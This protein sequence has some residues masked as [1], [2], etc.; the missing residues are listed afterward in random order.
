MEQDKKKVMLIFGGVSSEHEVS[1]TSAAS[2]LSHINTE[3]YDIIKVGI[4]KDGRWMQTEAEPFDIENGSWEE[5][6]SNKDVYLMPGAGFAGLD[7]DIVFPLLHG[8]NGEDGRMQGF[9]AI[10]GIPFVGS[11]S[12]ASAACMDKAVT[13]AVIDQ[14]EACDQAK[15]CVAHRGCDVE[16]AASV[17]DQFF[18]SKYPLFVKPANA[19]SSVGISKV[20]QMEGLPEAL[21][22]AFA[23]DN[24]AVVEEAIVGREIEVA[25]LGNEDP[26]ASCIGEILSANEF[27]DY[28]AKY[29]NIGSVTSIVTDLPDSLQEQIRQT[30][31]SIYEIMG[32]RGLAR[33]DFFLK[34]G[35]SGG[36][37]DGELVF[38]EINTMPGFTTIS[39]YPQLWEASG[40]GY[41]ELI[42]RLIELAEE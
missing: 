37:N 7:V 36:Y 2:V 40:I 21:N 14:A 27:Y 29:D 1:R 11:D 33:V 39:M 13:K 42:D 8:R 17:I 19:G 22:V 31:V 4:T 12:T 32:C 6:E 18:D 3:K 41:E 26:Q 23:E 35:P 16:E 38:N 9:L 25:V 24:K 20:K 10:A 34:E 5:H 30:A 15:C 28:V